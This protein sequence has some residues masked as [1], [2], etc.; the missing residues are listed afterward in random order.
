MHVGHARG[1]V[2]GDA[3]ARLLDFAGWEVTR[4][5]Y[6]NDGGAQ[7]DVLARSAF[8][9]YR[10]A[11]GLSPEIAEGLYPGD[12]LVPVGQAL[13]DLY[14]DSLLDK[15]ESEWL[16]PIRDFATEAM[17]GHDPRGPCAARHPDGRLLVREG[18]LRHRPDRG[19]HRPPPL[20][21]P[22]L[23]GRP[24]AAQGQ[25]PEDWEPRSRRCSARPRMATT[26]TA[27]SRS[28]R[29]WTYFAPDIAYHYDKTQRGFDL[30][31]DVFGADHGGYTKRMRAAVAALTNGASRSSSSS[32]SS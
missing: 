1:A 7:V 32:C 21:G 5:Y 6:I 26:W 2:F 27:P 25:A 30:L 9:R 20:A 13:K 8:E 11:N 18:P 23:R 28:P 12:Y 24:R 16:E 29:S 10:E 19:G 4:E 15:P 17:M 31:I 14:G 3:L 22:H